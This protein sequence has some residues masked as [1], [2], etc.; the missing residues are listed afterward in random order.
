[1]LSSNFR[2]RAGMTLVRGYE[3]AERIG[4]QAG[5]R[6]V[7]AIAG[8]VVGP[9]TDLDK[10]ASEQA[11]SLTLDTP[12]MNAA[13]LQ[14]LAEA[15]RHPELMCKLKPSTRAMLGNLTSDDQA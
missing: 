3:I 10:W 2:T 13:R 14:F 11:A 4:Q 7:G 15:Q 9:V 6:I 12:E 8:R 1:M 5:R